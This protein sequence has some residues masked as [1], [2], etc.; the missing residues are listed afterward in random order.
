MEVEEL[1]YGD[2]PSVSDTASADYQSDGPLVP[3]VPS[4]APSRARRSEAS[5][6]P[7]VTFRAVSPSSQ[8][9][10]PS[11][12]AH[13]LGTR[14]PVPEPRRG[15]KE[16]TPVPTP[17]TGK[18]AGAPP[19]TGAQKSP[20][21]KL[22]RGDP[23]QWDYR[24]SYREYER[25]DRVENPAMEVEED[26][27]RDSLSVTDTTSADSESEEA[28]APKLPPKAPHRRRRSGTSR[29]P[30]RACREEPLSNEDTPSLR[31][32]SP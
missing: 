13:T 26:L 15:K 29:L 16:A 22:A 18:V 12:R 4:K 6:L 7:R 27:H 20:P 32:R 17:E 19:E 2:S 3:K 23:P 24:D 28:L 8:E 30:S 5:K 9:E 31:A 14:E 10:T 21:P 1:L 25:T 11:S